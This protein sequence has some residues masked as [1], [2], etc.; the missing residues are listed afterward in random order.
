MTGEADTI[1]GILRHYAERL[2]DAPAILAP[3]RAPLTFQGLAHQADYVRETLN[4]W[5]IGRGDRVALVVPDR[6]DMAVAFLSVSGCATAAPLNPEY[7]ASEFERYLSDTRS[8]ALIVAAGLDT[9]VRAVAEGLGLTVIE[10]SSDHQA[11][12][13]TFKLSGGHRAV[14]DRPGPAQPADI[15]LV[16]PTSGTTSKPKIVPLCH[17]RMTDMARR[18]AR[19]YALDSNDRCLNIMPLAYH[20]GLNAALVLPLSAGCS[21][22][23][24]Q[25]F[26]AN[27]FFKALKEFSPTW[28]SA[29]PT[30]HQA[31]A[32]QAAKH[33]DLIAQGRL[34]FIRSGA[35][36]LPE[37]VISV[38]EK[39][40]NVPLIERYGM[41]ETNGTVTSNPM[42][43]G[44]RK[45]GTVGV[46]EENE[47]R[48]MDQDGNFLA[49]GEAGEIVVRGPCVFGGYDNDPEANADAFFDGWFRTGDEGVF[50]EDGYLTLTGRIKEVINRG[51]EKVSPVQV[52]AALMG[53]PAVKDAAAFP[54]PHPT[55]GEEVAAVVIPEANADLKAEDLQAYLGERLSGFKRPKMIVFAE[56]IP[57]GATGKVQRH[58]LAETFGVKIRTR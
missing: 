54:V 49:Q 22:V 36:R 48:I 29:G 46:A 30:H 16:L 17:A 35:G 34:R 5:G 37:D 19:A 31:I 39:A 13:G 56:E 20:H 12:A 26:D 38:L 4:G 21:V 18:N 57:K 14:A 45:P 44:K 27:E 6:P 15:A 23:L 55:L 25:F 24:P 50:D 33:E 51:G 53:H 1:G 43:P 42:P 10:L 52:D 58:K 11:P 28:Y 41:T 7:S 9:P 47:V 32:S 40:F 2:P 3:G 8:K